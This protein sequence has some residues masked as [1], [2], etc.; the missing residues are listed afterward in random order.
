MPLVA[1]IDEK[2]MCMHG[3]ISREMTS[4]DQIEAIQKPLD[5]PDGGLIA[6]LL[7]NDPDEDCREWEENERGCGYVFGKKPLE[8][9]LKKFDLDLICRGH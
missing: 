8:D 3:G 4:F 7:W 1:L 2:I 5:V 6:D 9:F